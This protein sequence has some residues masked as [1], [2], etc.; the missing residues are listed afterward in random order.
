MKSYNTI[1]FLLFVLLIMGAFA[2]MAQNTYGMRILGG[3]AVAFGL[4]F[5]YRFLESFRSKGDKFIKTKVELACLSVLSF[6][7]AL[8][9]FH[10]YF[11]FLETAFALAGLILAFI[12]GRRMIRR[13]SALQS[14]NSTLA[15]IIFIYYLSLL[16]FI[17]TLVAVPFLPQYTNYTG[18][19]AFVLLIGFLMAGLMAHKYLI[20]GVEVSVFKKVMEYKDNSV[21]L[22]SLFFII[23]L[24]MGLTKAGMLPS[25]Y[26]DDFPQAYF[27]LVGQAESGQEKP[28]NGKYRHQEFKEKYDVFLVKSRQANP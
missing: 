22:L 4:V 14:K 18:A 15:I 28:V 6:L 26:S 7:F 20:D 12:Y 19:L 21:I 8:R 9:I 11:P 23:S 16:L 27:R 25:M 10:F 3:V 1:F 2:S 24:Y 13:S 17:F 5:L